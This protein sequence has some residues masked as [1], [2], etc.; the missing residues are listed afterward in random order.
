MPTLSNAAITAVVSLCLIGSA[1]AA[2]KTPS[3]HYNWTGFYFGGNGGYAWGD[4]SVSK[5]VASPGNYFLPADAAQVNSTGWG[6][7]R[8]DGGIGGIQAGQNWQAG[9]VVYGAEVDFNVMSLSASRS[10]TRSYPPPAVGATHTINQS[11]ETDWLFT[12]RPRIG[13]ATDNWLLYATG[14]LAVTEIKYNTTFTDTFTPATLENG[15]ISK[16]KAGWA[17]GGGV[18]YGLTQNWSIKAEY[19]YLDFGKVSSIGALTAPGGTGGA[20][21]SNSA[22]LKV[23]IVRGG[24]NYRM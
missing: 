13:L 17:V 21:L 7:I 5:T 16:I 14:G 23:N 22:D 12:A 24:I 1:A 19:L 15:S 2:D 3:L 10:I 9:N 8:P 4:S 18:E 11:I 6:T 20:A